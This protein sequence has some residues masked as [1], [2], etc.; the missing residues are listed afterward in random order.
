MSTLCKLFHFPNLPLTLFLLLTLSACQQPTNPDIA[1][2]HKKSGAAHALEEWAMVR[3]YPNGRIRTDQLSRA[4]EAQRTL[5]LRN[6]NTE[7][8][9][10]GPKNI[11]GRTL[12]VAFHPADPDIQYIGSASGG[13]WKTTTAGVG[14]EAWERV[15]LGHPVL[16]VS[17]IAIQPDDPEV[18]YIGTGEVYNYTIAQPGVYNRLTRGSYGMGVL[19]TINGGLT[20]EKTIDWSYSDLRGVWDIIINPQNTNTVLVTTTVGTYLTHNAGDDWELIHEFPMGMD[21]EMHPQD[22]NIIW[23]SY[24]GYLSPQAGIFKSEDGGQSFDPL[25]GLPNDYTGKSLISISPS[26]PEVIYISMADALEGR[27]LYRSNDGGATWSVVN[28]ANIPTY[29]G[30]FSHDVAINSN[31]PENV[32]WAGV[33]AYKSTDGGSNFTKKTVWNAWDFG[34]V[35]VGGPEGPPEYA[36]ADI[37]AIYYAPFDPNTV[38]LATDGGIFVSTDNGE[39]WEGR[40]GGYQTQQFYSRFSSSASDPNLAM[41]GLQDNATAIYIGDDAWVRVIGGDGM[42]TAIHPQNPDILYGSAQRLN[43]RRST[44]GPFGSFFNISPESAEGEQFNFNG[45]FILVPQSPHVVL[46][47]GQRLHR[48]LDGGDNWSATSNFPVDTETGN[49]ILS[50]GV[51]EVNAERVMVTTSPLLGGAPGA[52]RSEDGGINWTKMEGLPDR[53]GMEVVFHPQSQDT[54]YVVFSGFDSPPLW[55]TENG[56]IS[57]ESISEGLPLIPASSVIID[58]EIPTDI[59]VATDLGV[60]ASFDGGQSWSA[61][62]TSVAEAVMAMHLSI[63]PVNRKLRVATHGL[64]AYQT[65]LRDPLLDVSQSAIG[66]PSWMGVPVPNPAT[67]FS[68]LPL[69]L[70]EAAHLSVHLINGQGQTVIQQTALRYSAGEHQIELDLSSLPGGVYYYE[71][72]GQWTSGQKR[73]SHTGRLSKLSY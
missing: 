56:G 72:S 62:S 41:G 71:V 52:F 58:P 68:R 35:P 12:C 47:G 29:Q 3:A 50:I 18:M 60:Y 13:L 11:G 63:S 33:E 16:G 7:W 51:S 30:W 42:C 10:L 39:S 45:P 32:L 22:T 5:S 43:M 67:E 54:A 31:N 73:F 21:L 55:R 15:P 70:P 14:I 26:D 4:Y 1:V 36:H 8:E 53:V 17:S 25:L 48:S 44:D 61:H 37:H 24:G 57:W 6:N 28:S 65:N 19:K 23:A 49:P 34:Q 27:G 46:A 69:Q 66:N 9:A 2:Q 59:Y 64:G 40:N 38:Y 20:W